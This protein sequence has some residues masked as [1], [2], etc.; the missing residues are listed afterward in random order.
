[1]I[2]FFCNCYAS[3]KSSNN[4]L[5]KLKCYSLLRFTV[6]IAANLILP[7]YFK[8][9]CKNKKYSLSN[10]KRI[11][12]KII[13]SLTSFPLR[14]NRLWLVIE[15]LLRQSCK[16]DII[17][18]WLSKDQYSSYKQIPYSLLLLQKRGLHIELRDGDIRSH[19]KYYYAFKEYH[20][21]IIITVDDDIFYSTKMVEMLYMSYLREPEFVHCLYAHNIQYD[22][23]DQILPYLKWTNNYRDGLN[24]FFGSG[25]GT[26]FIPSLLY[27][28]V[29]DYILAQK[30]C[31]TADDVWLNC[32]CRLNSLK[33]NLVQDSYPIL[34]VVNK[35]D[36]KLSSL[37]C[38][39]ENLND[40][41]IKNISEYYLKILNVDVFKKQ[42]NNIIK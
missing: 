38:G 40:V 19:K 25:G 18:L 15:T 24:L 33:I 1:M 39:K 30:L 9:T 29:L 22:S 27:E 8:C 20:N 21:D 3:I 14:I 5:N 37:N 26:L 23:D 10:N 32:M 41:Q 34:P 31:Y 17:V 7:L 13:I 42:Y 11:E 35:S 6:R 16:P 12:R 36:V 28:D 4:L 2:D